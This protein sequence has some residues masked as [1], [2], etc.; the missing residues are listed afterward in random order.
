MKIEELL[1]IVEKMTP[2]ELFAGYA[3]PDTDGEIEGGSLCI[4]GQPE[5]RQDGCGLTKSGNYICIVS[6]P[7]RITNID[8]YNALGI[9]AL[10]NHA[11]RIITELQVENERLRKWAAFSAS[12]IKSGEPWT[13]ECER[14]FNEALESK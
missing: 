1:E 12:C 2:G 13:V 6:P 3:P 5:Y 8:E 4:V 7:H 10:K 11:P 9:V 14:M